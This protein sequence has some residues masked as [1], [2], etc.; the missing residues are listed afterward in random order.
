MSYFTIALAALNALSQ[1][2]TQHKQLQAQITAN[3]KTARGYMQQMNYSFQN[4]EQQ[5]QDAFASAI[6]S[7]TKNRMLAHEQE[8][9]V[10]AAVNED[11]MAGGRTSNLINRS[12]KGDESRMASSIIGNYNT[13][14]DEIDLN[15]ESVLTSTKNAIN[16][17]G[18]VETP[19]YFST[20]LNTATNYLNT[21]NTLQNIGSRR[22]KANIGT[23]QTGNT[24]QGTDNGMPVRGVD[25]GNEVRKEDYGVSDSGDTVRGVDL[26]AA[27]VKYDT[28]ASGASSSFSLFSSNS[29]FNSNPSYSYYSGDNLTNELNE[30]YGSYKGGSNKWQTK[31]LLL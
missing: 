7:L 30:T 2:Q 20:I 4:Y 14:S 27:S 10:S 9:T 12:V 22:S 19:S 1:N 17:I 18:S 3:N 6:D 26:D 15:K 8:A 24:A 16:S 29:I 11:Q 31:S 28:N 23:V 25:I 5:R 21:Y 13:K